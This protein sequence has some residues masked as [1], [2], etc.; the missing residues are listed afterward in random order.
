VCFRAGFYGQQPVEVGGLGGWCVP[1]REV[2]VPP[3]EARHLN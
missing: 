1:P 2:G 3:R